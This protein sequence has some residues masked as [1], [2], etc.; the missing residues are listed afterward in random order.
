MNIK[1]LS[2]FALVLTTLSSVGQLVVTG[3]TDID[4]L[5]SSI[6]GNGVSIS[7]AQITCSSNGFG[8]YDAQSTNLGSNEGVL[9]TTGDIAIG[10]GPN[11]EEDASANANTP[12]SAILTTVTSR[13]TFDACMLEMDIIPRGDTLSF[14]FVFA[15]EEYNEW[16]GSQYNDVFGFFISGPGITGDPGI[17]NDHN[18]ALIPGTSTAIAINN[19]NANINPQYFFDN[20]AGG[21]VQYDGFT[22]GLKAV[23]AVQPCET[24]HLK[25]VIADAS[26][27]MWDSGVFIEKIESNDVGM[28]S[29]SASGLDQMIE[30][31]N[32]GTVTFMRQSA[33][34]QSEDVTFYLNGTWVERLNGMS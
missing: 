14:D 13:P 29:T 19:V 11:D 34:N 4:A 33:T 8:Y 18:I 30:G 5:A 26:D 17:G 23:S 25:L 7:N 20:P 1:A 16:V 3:T 24:Y 12:G 28:S 15:S 6:A 32:D 31:C 21:T 9:L 10:V 27:R 2:F 22:V